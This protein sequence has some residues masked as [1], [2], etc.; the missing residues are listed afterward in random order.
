MTNGPFAAQTAG[1]DATDERRR[2]APGLKRALAPTIAII[3]SGCAATTPPPRFSSVSPAD[4]TAPEATTPAPSPLL[5]GGGELAEAPEP[6]PSPEP[7]EGHEG[8]SMPGMT[9]P[10]P[11]ASPEPSYEGHTTPEAGAASETYTCL[12]HPQ[13]AAKA[14]GSCP[15]CGMTLVKKAA[16]SKERHP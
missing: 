6:A 10:D 14:P 9:A 5:T 11:K 7:M 16:K 8:H 1:R 4:P 15:I 2:K 13:V 12:M 3:L